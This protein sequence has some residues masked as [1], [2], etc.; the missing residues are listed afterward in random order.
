MQ[1]HHYTTLQNPQEI[2]LLVLAPR[3]GS[4]Q[5]H[6]WLKYVLLS[7][8]PVFEALSYVW[9][10]SSKP[11]EALCEGKSIRITES[12]FIAL[13]YLRHEDK[14]RSILVDAI[15]INQGDALEKSL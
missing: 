6:C 2:R 14:E 15:C 9:G 3:A 12:L 4:A 1:A 5:I 7:E 13:A 10:D 11:R 8:N